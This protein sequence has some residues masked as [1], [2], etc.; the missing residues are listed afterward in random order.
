[1]K[2]QGT[3]ARAADLVEEIEDAIQAAGVTEAPTFENDLRLTLVNQAMREIRSGRIDS[4]GF[5]HLV[6]TVL[7]SLG[8]SEVHILSRSHEDKG[9]DIIAHFPLATTFRFA[10]AV[11]VK[12]YRPEPPIG[13]ETV[14]Q[15]VRGMEAEGTDLGWV[16]TSGTYSEEALD[17]KT[18]VEEDLGFRLELVDGE[19][20]A[21]M[22]VEGGLKEVY[23]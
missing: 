2:T 17:R 7:K 22:I 14:D 23:G 5:E 13:A 9:A 3:C 8:A 15:L 12:H 10:L 16:V 6:A 1:M 18:K 19:Q 4:Y 11:Q 21:A 20:L